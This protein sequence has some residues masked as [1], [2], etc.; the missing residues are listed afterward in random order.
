MPRIV[1]SVVVDANP[2]RVWEIMCDANRYHEFVVPTDKVLEAPEGPIERGSVYRE[3]GGIPPFK[4]ESVW[5]VTEFE[6]PSHQVHIGD[7]GT[8][9]M[10]LDLKMAAVGSGTRITFDIDFKPRWWKAPLVYPMWF[11][12]MGGRGKKAMDQTAQNFKKFAESE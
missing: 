12:F 5:H 8:M 11:A 1:T 6:K 10:T 9:T 7:D 3:H 2:E 4:A